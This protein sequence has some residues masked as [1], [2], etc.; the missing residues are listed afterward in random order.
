MSALCTASQRQTV[1]VIMSERNTIQP[2][3]FDTDSDTDQAESTVEESIIRMCQNV[4]EWYIQNILC[5][6]I[7]FQPLCNYACAI[8]N[9]FDKVRERHALR[10]TQTRHKDIHRDKFCIGMIYS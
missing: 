9:L 7:L 6:C 3:I 4:S 5:F 10:Q 8:R 2:Y 1:R